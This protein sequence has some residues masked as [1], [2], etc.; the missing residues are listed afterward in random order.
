MEIALAV[1][2]L[3]AVIAAGLLVRRSRAGS[4]QQPPK[5][6]RPDDRASGR[7][8]RPLQP[9]DMAAAPAVRRTGTDTAAAQRGVADDRSPIGS[10][11]RGSGGGGSAARL[12]AA[13]LTRGDL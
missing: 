8:G 10:G 13:P 7:N 1:V 12:S 3:L 2:V 6:A 11:N 9:P 4:E 5:E